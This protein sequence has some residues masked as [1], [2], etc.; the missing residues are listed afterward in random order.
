MDQAWSILPADY[1][2]WWLLS[3]A[4]ENSDSAFEWDN[5]QACVNKGPGRCAGQFRQ[6]GDQVLRGQVRDGGG[7]PDGG[8]WGAREV[9]LAAELEGRCARL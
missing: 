2:R 3:H 5:F 1:W 8:T 7:F 6:P 4:P 9:A